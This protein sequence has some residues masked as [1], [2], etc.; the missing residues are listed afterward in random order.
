[1]MHFNGL[2]CFS[3][4]LMLC[5]AMVPPAR[6][7]SDGWP[8]KEFL[9]VQS[10]P[11]GMLPDSL[12]SHQQ[13]TDD[14]QTALT[15]MEVFLTEVAERYEAM[16]FRAPELERVE[17]VSGG[18]AYKVHFFDYDDHGTSPFRVRR[19]S[20]STTEMQIDTSR[21]FQKD[22]IP[23]D[24]TY[25]HLAHELF[26]L[27]QRAYQ[28]SEDVIQN[29]WIIEGQAQ[30]MGMYMLQKILR[31]DPYAGSQ[32]GYRLGARPYYTPLQDIPATGVPKADYL[33]ASFWRYVG[34]VFAASKKNGRAGVQPIE[35][36]Y[37]YL[38]DMFRH[39]YPSSA[40]LHA[41]LLWT[42]QGLRNTLG[43]GLDRVY[44]NFVST[45]AAY[46]PT[47]LT[48]EPE[49][50][51]EVAEINWRNFVFN[52]CER[53]ANLT[54]TSV[55]ANVE[56]VVDA[57]AAS[58]FAVNVWGEGQAGLSLQIRSGD[59]DALAALRIGTLGGAKVGS[60]VLVAPLP[61]G[62]YL[63]H[64]RF[65]VPAGEPAVFVIS[66]VAADPTTTRKVLLSLNASSDYWESNMTQP[67]QAVSATQ[68]ATTAP[69]ASMPPVRD[70]TREQAAKEFAAG[71]DSLSNRSA[72]SVGVSHNYE[73]RGCVG[74]AFA[75]SGCGPTTAIH[76]TLM[77]GAFADGFQTTGTG[78]GL[79][80][81][82]SQ[83][84]A[85]ADNGPFATDKGLR[86]AFGEAAETEGS[87]V[88]ILIPAID[89]GFTGTFTEARI[90]VNGGKGHGEFEA[91]G[92][93]DLVPGR[94]R[95]FPYTGSVTIEEFTPF[96]LRGSFSGQLTDL[97]SVDFSVFGDDHALP[98]QRQIRG[99]FA[100]T[101][102]W[103]GDK[104]VTVYPVSG[105]EDSAMA[106]LYEVF[107]AARNFDIEGLSGIDPTTRD[108]SGS[109]YTVG[110]LPL[111][112][113]TEMPVCNCECQIDR[114]QP[115]TCLKICKPKVLACGQ[116][117]Q[118]ASRLAVSA[119][120]QDT[121]ISGAP[122]STPG[123]PERPTREEYIQGLMKH[124][125]P[126]DRIDFLVREM[127][128]FMAENGGW[129]ER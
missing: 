56:L 52:G 31:K 103:E 105:G 58:C 113:V 14:E 44:A 121:Q 120:G 98:V 126:P 73:V 49:H 129:A 59:A 16:G 115:R 78:G 109:G 54:A 97:S 83:F 128:A 64:W 23:L 67:R 1:M 118:L 34:E 87:Y 91:R 125:Y 107:P 24:R 7:Q 106:D 9:I 19:K 45:F 111:T 46:V 108:A 89:Y 39:P 48:K 41:D 68:D 10:D 11:Y 17:G 95:L 40:S 99:R 101:A 36:D 21:P 104:R 51:A 62:G 84:I 22:G 65:Q 57:N 81:V 90:G 29:D 6:A 53:T 37:R 38:V 79:A 96:L 72:N 114:S 74:Q 122:L 32:D 92:P 77:P 88:H 25:E 2:L 20:A 61:G 5:V 86:N 94:G 26:H 8:T 123:N 102:P 117:K 100:I 85:M 42:D 18:E 124:G 75:E 33:T 80:Q 119:M 27:V 3:L 28:P 55:S 13:L 12:Q 63:G 30:A 15:D 66:N 69:A 60:P 76:L 71:L 50:S 47:R 110:M 82:M 43:Y 93:E 70:G 35:P 112:E 116:A 127:D 4:G